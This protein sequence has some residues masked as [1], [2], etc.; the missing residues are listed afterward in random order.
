MVEVGEVELR[1]D[2]IDEQIIK[3]LTQPMKRFKT[4]SSQ[5]LS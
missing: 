4:D 1:E 5:R 3:T 2:K